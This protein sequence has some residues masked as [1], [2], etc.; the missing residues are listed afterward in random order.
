ALRVAE[1][2]NVLATHGIVPTRPETGYGY[3]QAASLD[4]PLDTPHGIPVLPVAEFHEKPDRARAESFIAAGN[5]F[6]NSGMFFWR[7]DTF[8]DEL[9]AAQPKMAA[10]GKAIAEALARG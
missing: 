7:L 5:Y 10:A 8:W 9:A 1:E 3:I 4:A 6:W 2:R